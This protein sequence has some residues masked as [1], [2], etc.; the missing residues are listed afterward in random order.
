MRR[1]ISCRSSRCSRPSRMPREPGGEALGPRVLDAR[2]HALVD[3]VALARGEQDAGAPVEPVAGSARTPPWSASARSRTVSGSR[4][5]AIQ[6][7]NR[8]LHGEGQER[9]S[10]KARRQRVQRVADPTDRPPRRARRRRSRT[11]SHPRRAR[12]RSSSHAGTRRIAQRRQHHHAQHAHVGIGVGEELGHRV[13]AGR[14][15][16]ERRHAPRAHRGVSLRRCDRERASD[17]L[18][19]RRHQSGDDRLAHRRVTFERQPAGQP[20]DGR[21]LARRGP[22]PT[23][24]GPRTRAARARPA[25]RRCRAASR[26]D[27][28]ARLARAASGRFTSPITTTARARRAPRPRTGS[29]TRRRGARPRRACPTRPRCPRT[30]RSCDRPHD[31]SRTSRPRRRRPCP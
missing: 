20:G 31:A 9:V 29:R 27:R 6:P 8:D 28:F 2:R 4:R 5:L 16:G 1:L 26:A 3:E 14:H 25:G 15:R 23:A 18:A 24:A 13:S 22:A 21:P 19:A 10:G 17:R 12:S 7:L 11:R 30:P